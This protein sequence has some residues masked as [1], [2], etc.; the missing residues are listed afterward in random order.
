MLGDPV[1]PPMLPDPFP[2]APQPWDRCFSPPCPPPASRTG[3]GFG[4]SAAAAVPPLPLSGSNGL[5]EPVGAKTKIYNLQS[6]PPPTLQKREPPRG[7]FFR[8]RAPIGSC[9]RVQRPLQW[10][11]GHGAC[12]GA[13]PRNPPPKGRSVSRGPGAFLDGIGLGTLAPNFEKNQ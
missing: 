7:Q 13:P 5:G 1:Q 12:V 2:E 11:R 10:A 9:A 8:V 4:L 3:W 6:L